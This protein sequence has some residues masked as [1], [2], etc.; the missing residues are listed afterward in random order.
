[1]MRTIWPAMTVLALLV[2]LSGCFPYR[3][4]QGNPHGQAYRDPPRYV[5]TNNDPPGRDCWR[6]GGDWVCRRD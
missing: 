4:W 2:G 1:M 5:N 6:Q 3:D